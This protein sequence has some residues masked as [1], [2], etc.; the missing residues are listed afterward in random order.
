[1]RLTSLFLLLAKLNFIFPYKNL[2]ATESGK[3]YKISQTSDEVGSL[4]DVTIT[5]D[6]TKILS[7][8]VLEKLSPDYIPKLFQNLNL[9]TLK[10]KSCG[11][12]NW[13]ESSFDRAQI[14]N[15]LV[16]SNVY[17]VIRDFTF[18]KAINLEFLNLAHNQVEVV[19]KFAFADAPKLQYISLASNKITQIEMGTFN[20]PELQDLWLSNNRIKTIEARA[21]QGAKKLK[22]IILG[23][24]QIQTLTKEIFYG[25]ESLA[26]ICFERNEIESLQNGTFS[27]TKTL[28]KL[29]LTYNNLK[30]IGESSFDGLENLEELY[31]EHNK[32]EAVSSETFSRMQKLKIFSLS[33]NSCYEGTMQN[34]NV[35]LTKLVE[36]KKCFENYEKYL[37][38]EE[39]ES[40]FEVFHN[41]T[42]A[43]EAKNEIAEREEDATESKNDEMKNSKSLRKMIL[44]F[45][46]NILIVT[47]F[48]NK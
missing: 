6:S 31:L 40:D 25:L 29:R 9:T 2:I 42:V 3:N 43:D 11:K 23:T 37:E 20:C 26:E 4:E 21:F 13:N 16:S 39:V 1:M 14:K 18:R 24:N 32:I 19:S 41:E 36:L 46:V 48:L 28:R 45:I 8:A 33:Y 17:S 10:L 12:I 38:L 7:S 22:K 30:I 5:V 44:I 27:H 35:D 15:L 47:Y 34:V